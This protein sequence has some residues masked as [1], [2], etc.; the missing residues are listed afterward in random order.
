MTQLKCLCSGSPQSH[1]K[2]PLVGEAYRQAR[3]EVKTGFLG[4]GRWNARTSKMRASEMTHW[5]KPFAT[6]LDDLSAIPG[7]HMVKEEN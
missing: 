5:I 3:N 2:M 6:K 7:A 4:S 1:V